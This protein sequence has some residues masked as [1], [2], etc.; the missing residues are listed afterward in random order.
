MALLWYGSALKAN[1]GKNWLLLST[2]GLDLI[3][4][5]AMHPTSSAPKKPE[6]TCERPYCK[7]AM[8]CNIYKKSKIKYSCKPS[9]KILKIDSIFQNLPIVSEK[10]EE[11]GNWALFLDM[12]LFP[13]L[14]PVWDSALFSAESQLH[15]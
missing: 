8:L 13:A 7:R 3:F 5:S 10:V 14:L 1:T 4:Q 9:F 2:L 12:E 11:I 6:L 15:T